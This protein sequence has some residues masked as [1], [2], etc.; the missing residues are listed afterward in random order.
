MST[1]LLVF[2]Y[3]LTGLTVSFAI[4]NITIGLQKRSEKTYL[5]LG[6]MSICVG[7]YY[8]LFPHMTFTQPLPLITKAGFFFFLANFALLPWFFSYYTGFR[9]SNVQWALSFGMLIS[10]VLLILTKDF[11][12]PIIWNIFAHVVLTGTIIYGFKAAI[13]QK[14]KGDFWSAWLLLGALIVFSLLTIDDVF[15]MHFPSVYPFEVDKDILPFDYFLVLFMVIMSLKLAGEIQYKYQLEK[16]NNAKEKRWGNLLKKVQL[17][18]VGVDKGG[19]INYVNP[20][21]LELTG[22]RKEDLIGN[23]YLQLVPENKKDS[24]KAQ[25]KT[26]NTPDDLPYYQNN[27]VTKSGD[28]KYIAWSLVGINDESGNYISSISIGS[29][30]TARHKAYEE[31]TQLKSRLEEENIFLKAELNKVREVGEIKGKSDA[32]NYVLQ[33]ALQVAPTDATVLLEGE[34]GVGKEL[35]ANYIQQNSNRCDMPFIKIN[36]AAIPANLLESELFG[37]LKGA[38][39]GADRTKKGLVEIADGGTL[40]LDE[41]GDF[42]FEL[43]AKLLRFLQEGEYLPLGSE[44]TRKADVRIIA[45]TNHELLRLIDQR[46][47]RNDLYYRLYIYPI[48]IPALRDRTIDIPEFAEYFI[49]HY[50]KKHNKPIKKVSKLV[51]EELKKYDWPGNVR[52]LE[53]ILERAVIV[54][55]TDTIKVKDISLFTGENS[56]KHK[57]NSNLFNTLETMERD[58]IKAV[59]KHCKW[60]VHGPKGAAQILGINPN[61]LRSRMKKLN[62]IR[63]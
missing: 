58:H 42:P 40:F 27:I 20:F 11:T 52:E 44:S 55:N 33:R 59:L 35:I 7:I 1:S 60:Q 61:T 43:Q 19:I 16:I 53:N 41:I 32:I 36:C 38:F 18:V 28:E 56:N 15:R 6:L 50:A 30:I 14:K 51:I 2:I 9:N 4:I 31:I 45:A 8:A 21:L 26:I 49:K 24:L 10:Y 17:L 29:D 62:I 54:S 13:Y 46:Q 37:H 48:T 39:T 3:F 34:T 47:F 57:R 5:F 22:F 12:R 23:H 25:A 63:P